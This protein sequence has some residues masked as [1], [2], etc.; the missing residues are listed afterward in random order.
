MKC[1][2]HIRVNL[3]VLAMLPI[4]TTMFQR[5]FKEHDKGI[6]YRFLPQMK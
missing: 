5:G 3:H 2:V 1:D 6:K 4:G